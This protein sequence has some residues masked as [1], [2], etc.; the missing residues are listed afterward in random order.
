[1][2]M[3]CGNS[4]RPRILIFQLAGHFA[5]RKGHDLR[6]RWRARSHLKADFLFTRGFDAA[7]LDA[8]L[9]FMLH[10]STKQNG[11]IGTVV[12]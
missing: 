10:R 2:R 9:C 4:K 12:A 11:A 6:K 7:V 1:M 8:G 5:N 3:N